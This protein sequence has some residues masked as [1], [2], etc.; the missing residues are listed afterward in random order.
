MKEYPILMND[1]MARATLELRK[2]QT[3]RVI[4]PQPP[5]NADRGV[6]CWPTGGEGMPK[7]WVDKFG[8]MYQV[9][10]VCDHKEIKFIPS[11]YGA[12]GDRLWVR[13]THAFVADGMFALR[14]GTVFR[15]DNGIEW[16]EGD[17]PQ[18]NGKTVY[19]YDKPDNWKWRP[20]IHMP[21]WACRTICEVTN[22]RVE[23]IQDIS[24]EDAIAEGVGFWGCDTIEV[25]QDLWDSLY[26]KR[27]HPWDNNDLVW[28]YEFKVLEPADA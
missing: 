26:A 19:N 8:Y 15:S 24:D 13:E 17:A 6:L 7:S 2:T 14:A 11:P 21:R 9:P 28:V 18:L 4:K 20:S 3:R 5:D 25:F 1:E 27:G 10:S 23:R 12:P 22:V 16:I